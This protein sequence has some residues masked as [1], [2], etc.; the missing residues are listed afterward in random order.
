MTRLWIDSRFVPVTLLSAAT[1][2]VVR[3][4]TEAVDGY[5]ALV[6]EVTE[7]KS[8]PDIYEIR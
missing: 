8:G 5:N 6:I 4:K 7:S 1:Q 3:H 2:K